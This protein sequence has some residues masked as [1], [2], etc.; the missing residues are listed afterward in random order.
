MRMIEPDE[1][2]DFLA[3][4]ERSGLAEDDFALLETDTTDPKG[5]ENLGLQGYVT[6]A[7]LST[8]VTK[9]YVIGDESDWLQHF[10]KDLEAGVFNRPE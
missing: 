5:D 1:H 8:Q 9:E 7:R 10:R 3:T 4:L 6:I 2:K